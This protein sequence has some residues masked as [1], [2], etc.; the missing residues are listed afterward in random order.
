LRHASHV[1]GGLLWRA[2]LLVQ[3]K[4]RGDPPHYLRDLIWHDLR[5]AVRFVFRG[6]RKPAHTRPAE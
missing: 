6:G 4:D 2:R 5:A 3:R 1:A